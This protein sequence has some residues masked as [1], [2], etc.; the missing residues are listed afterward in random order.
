MRKSH[1][2]INGVCAK[3]V[4]PGRQL[5]VSSRQSGIA[6]LT[7]LRVADAGCG[8]SMRYVEGKEFQKTQGTPSRKREVEERTDSWW[9]LV[10][11][12]DRRSEG[13]EICMAIRR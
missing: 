11:S 1:T 3:R 9:V 10:Q 4:V 7:D 13:S 8:V 2:A 6:P 12:E 5:L